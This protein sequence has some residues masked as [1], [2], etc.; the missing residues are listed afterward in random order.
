VSLS[1]GM[2]LDYEVGRCVFQSSR[3]TYFVGF[4]IMN[5]NYRLTASIIYLEIKIHFLFKL[6]LLLLFYF[7][8]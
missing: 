1:F 8:F 6:N 4:Q 3:F 2:Q 5:L 7:D